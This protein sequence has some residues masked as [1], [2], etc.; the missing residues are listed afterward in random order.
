MGSSLRVIKI[1]KDP[2]TQEDAYTVEFECIVDDSK[3]LITELIKT[4]IGKKAIELL[5]ASNFLPEEKV[6]TE[7][8]LKMEAEAEGEEVKKREEELKE[9]GRREEREKWHKYL[10]KKYRKKNEVDDDTVETLPSHKTQKEEQEDYI[11]R[12]Y[13]RFGLGEGE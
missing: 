6:K 3:E 7:E 12:V 10:R 8:E 9:E 11:A 13:H 2:Y 5:N 4:P 1:I